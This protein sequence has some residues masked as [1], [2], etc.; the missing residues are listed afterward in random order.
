MTL[1]LRIF[2]SFR[3]KYYEDDILAGPQAYPADYFEQ[4]AEH[5]FNAVWLRGILRNLATTDALPSLAR[6]V[7]AHQDAL[8]AVVERAGRFGVKVLLYLNEPLCLPPDDPFWR[9]HPDAMGAYGDSGMDEWWGTHALCTST[10]VVRQWLREAAAGLFRDVP[11]LG[12]WFLISASEHLTHC[13]SHRGWATRD[14]RKHDCPRCA[15]RTPSAVAAGVITDL[16]DGTRASSPAAHCIAWNWSWTMYDEDPQEALLDALPKDVTLLLDFERGGHR[17]M[18][19]GKRIFV[20]E[21]SLAFVGPSARF[22]AGYRAARKRGLEVMAKL[23]IGT[24][25]ELATVPNLPLVDHVYEKL[26]RADE[27]GLAGFVGTWNFGNAFSLNTAAVGQYVRGRAQ[28]A[29]AAQATPEEFVTRLAASYFPGADAAGVAGA[30]A[31]FS[32]AMQHFPFDM[33]MLYYG[34]ANYALTY[35]LTMSPLTG[36]SMGWSWMMHERGDDLAP[37]LGQFTLEEVIDCF[38]ALAR[39]WQRGADALAAA[40]AGC[41][42]VRAAQE[43]GVA[44]T[45][46]ACF[47]STANVYRTYRLRKEQPPDAATQFGLIVID[48]IQNLAAALPCLRADERLGFH[49]ECQ[50]RQFTAEAVEAK[51]KALRPVS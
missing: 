15:E 42:D 30:V 46:G 12:G 21:Y 24:T 28:D 36:K 17:T 47:R 8:A 43:L 16:R 39:Q 18:P 29:A 23:Q 41:A 38:T 35:P 2:R 50:G 45:A 11:Q 19:S 5:G 14:G 33:S 32:A 48:E 10:P 25:H 13:Y 34:P 22:M 27:L 7:A 4:L 1:D 49:A 37:S 3:A 20:D 26:R 31:I 44:R 6:E 40:L 9:E 51:L